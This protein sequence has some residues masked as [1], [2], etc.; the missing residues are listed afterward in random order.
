[1]ATLH[2][3]FFSSLCTIINSIEG[4]RKH[5]TNWAPQLLRP[6]LC[7]HVPRSIWNRIGQERKQ[8]ERLGKPTNSTSHCD[9][10]IV[11]HLLHKPKCASQCNDNQFFILSKARSNFHLSVLESIFITLQKPN[12]CRQKEFI[13]K[14]KLL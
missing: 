6:A 13:Y 2:L 4:P 11:N 8:P 5:P 3:Q 14:R 1:M 7:Q 9:S 12:L 10:A